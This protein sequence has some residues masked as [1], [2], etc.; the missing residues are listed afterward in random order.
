MA[1]RFQNRVDYID[2]HAYGLGEVKIEH[3]HGTQNKKNKFEEDDRDF[4][5]D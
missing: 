5:K 3:E 1:S 2:I 4:E